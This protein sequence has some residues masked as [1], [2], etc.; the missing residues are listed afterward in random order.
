[1]W[2][3]NS[4]LKKKDKL[5]TE[6]IRRDFRKYLETKKGKISGD[7]L[8][9]NITFQNVWDIAKAVLRRKFI[10]VNTLKERKKEREKER[11]RKKDSSQIK[12]LTLPEG[13]GKEEQINLKVAKG[14][15]SSKLKKK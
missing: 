10:A 11:K 7:K 15:K 14:R 3:L 13:T 6:E 5:I 1:M 12:N 9:Q 2:K 4:A 8:K